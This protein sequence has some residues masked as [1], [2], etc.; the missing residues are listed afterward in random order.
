M[1][2]THR[3]Q[4]HHLAVSG[5]LCFWSSSHGN[6]S[7]APGPQRAMSLRPDMSKVTTSN[8]WGVP[9]ITSSSDKV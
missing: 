5:S 6:S 3:G 1:R 8:L 2:A 7:Y 9:F 4:A